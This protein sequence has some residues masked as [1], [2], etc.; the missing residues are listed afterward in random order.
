M[1]RAPRVD[2][3]E[4]DAPAGAAEVAV[5]APPDRRRVDVGPPRHVVEVP[6]PLV[7]VVDRQH[8]LV[9]LVG[10][11][12]LRAQVAE[13]LVHPVRRVGAGHTISPPRRGRDL[14]APRQRRVPVVAQVVVVEQ[15]A[16]RHG[17]QQPAH[18]RGGPRLLVEPGV[19]LEVLDLVDDLGVP[20]PVGL[21]EPGEDLLGRV[22]GVHLVAEQQEDVGPVDVVARHHPPGQRHE[23]IGAELVEVG[24]VERRRAPAAP[25]RQAVRRIEVRRADHARRQAGSG[26][27]PHP[28]AVEIDLVLGRRLHR[29][30]LEPH[31]RV[32][33]A[34]DRPRR[35]AVRH[36]GRR[37][38]DLAG[39]VGLE[40][41]R[42]PALVDVPQHGT[43]E[44]VGMVVSA[45]VCCPHGIG[46]Y[47]L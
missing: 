14:L 42:R 46:G 3:D 47:P 43:D 29:Q 30:V 10:V 35:G 21:P 44:Q 37:D 40:P 12:L 38:D 8:L 19:L 18:D 26:H 1:A 17:R 5:E 39:P 31:Q 16:A 25:E 27:R 32:V 20:L 28:V 33:V 45:D 11:E 23:G 4:P 2:R 13:V 15:H 36:P 9:H 34:V 6:G 41:D 24:V 7:V 22:V